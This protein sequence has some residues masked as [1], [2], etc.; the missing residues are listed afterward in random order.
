[1]NIEYAI[2]H[3]QYLTF[4]IYIFNII[5]NPSQA[6]KEEV[7]ISCQ[8]IRQNEIQ[9]RQLYICTRQTDSAPQRH[10]KIMDHLRNCKGKKCMALFEYLALIDANTKLQTTNQG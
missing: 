8:D 6:H 5:Y 3:I 7:M 1:M 9:I 4:I 2:F 10:E